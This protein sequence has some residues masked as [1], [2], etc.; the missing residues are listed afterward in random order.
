MSQAHSQR[1]NE[2]WHVAHDPTSLRHSGQAQMENLE[3]ANEHS[4][5]SIAYEGEILHHVNINGILQT[6]FKPP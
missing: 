4:L 2:K 5:L 1:G 3:L 6:S